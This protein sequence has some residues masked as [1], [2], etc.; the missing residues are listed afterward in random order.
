MYKYN[1]FTLSKSSTRNLFIPLKISYFIIS[2]FFLE[3]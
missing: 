2:T 1:I 3:I